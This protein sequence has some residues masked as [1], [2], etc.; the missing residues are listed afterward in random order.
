MVDWQALEGIGGVATAAAVVVAVAFGIV[1]M[2]HADRARNETAAMEILR[3][4]HDEKFEKNWPIVLGFP[5][6]VTLDAIRKMGKA[7]EDAAM[8]VQYHYETMGM[9]VFHRAVPLAMF[10]HASGGLGRKCWRKLRRYVADYRAEKELVN[11]AEW[12][13]WLAERL[14]AH[15]E[16][17]KATGAHLAHR[18][19]RP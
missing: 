10:D 1:Q 4:A 14:D 18:D 7:A 5:D 16:P 17:C 13:E 9:L 12:F 2:R 15:P 19:W 3:A 8:A 6:D 11:F